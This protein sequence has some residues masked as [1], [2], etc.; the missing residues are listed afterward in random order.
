MKFLKK[1][2]KIEYEEVLLTTCESQV[3]HDSHQINKF[4]H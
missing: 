3:C 4:S 1:V 2:A